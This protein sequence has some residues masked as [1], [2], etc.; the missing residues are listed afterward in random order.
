MMKKQW[1]KTDSGIPYVRFTSNKNNFLFEAEIFSDG[2][3]FVSFSMKVG[4]RYEVVYRSDQGKLK[5]K[6]KDVIKISHAYDELEYLMIETSGN[7][8]HINF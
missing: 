3:G 8:E 2:S 1:K 4:H 7:F 5:D 6:L